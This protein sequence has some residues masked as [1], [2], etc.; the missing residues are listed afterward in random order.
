MGELADVPYLRPRWLLR[1]LEKQACDCAFQ[2]KRAPDHK[3]RY[4][5]RRVLVVLRGQGVPVEA[6]SRVTDFF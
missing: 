2:G 6:A 1:Q 3:V 5:R 4:A